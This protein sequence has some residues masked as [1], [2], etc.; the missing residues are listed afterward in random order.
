MDSETEPTSEQSSTTQT[1]V[2]KQQSNNNPSSSSDNAGE[3]SI[4]ESPD[5]APSVELT[6]KFNK[7]NNNRIDDDQSGFNSGMEPDKD[8]YGEAGEEQQGQLQTGRRKPH[9]A[10]HWQQ[11]DGARNKYQNGYYRYIMQQQ[12]QQQRNRHHHFATQAPLLDQEDE[13]LLTANRASDNLMPDEEYPSTSG[14]GYYPYNGQQA[15]YKQ[16]FLP[17]DYRS[18][19]QNRARV[20]QSV[21]ARPNDILMKPLMSGLDDMMNG[22]GSGPLYEDD[23][24][25]QPGSGQQR[26]QNY[27]PI[28]NEDSFN[29]IQA[30]RNRHMVTQPNNARARQGATQVITGSAR[31][32][33]PLSDVTLNNN[34]EPSAS[35]MSCNDCQS[36]TRRFSMRQFCHHEFAIKATILNKFMAEDWTKF[37]VEIDD[38]FKSPDM[39]SLSRNQANTNYVLDNMVQSDEAL[40][41]ANQANINSSQVIQSDLMQPSSFNHKIKVGTVQSIWVPTED[42]TCKCP[43][44]KLRST[45]LLMGKSTLSL[46]ETHKGEENKFISFDLL[47]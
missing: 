6:S 19:G 14:R 18:V 7:Q 4:A 32:R 24:D 46:M 1:V 40:L 10:H 28:Y 45:F 43:K 13:L 39:A 37:D 23:S 41:P 47:T 30:P 9:K 42:L 17:S 12:Q 20:A 21:R 33:P 3:P 35:Q 34:Q 44:L 5:I 11:T 16:R 26:Q 25:Q 15:T 2:E 27:V 38:I 36:R 29:Q 22:A 31:Y 8:A